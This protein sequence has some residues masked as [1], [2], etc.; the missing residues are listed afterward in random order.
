MRK[1][2]E[3]K[4][5]KLEL[6]LSPKDK[7]LIRHYAAVKGIGMSEAVLSLCVRV[8]SQELKQMK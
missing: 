4:T 2:K 7:E 3:T 1:E 6:R 5:T 8:F